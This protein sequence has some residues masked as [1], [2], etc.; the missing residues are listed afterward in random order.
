MNKMKKMY[1]IWGIIVVL[2][3]AL[4]TAFGFLYKNK[5]SVYK[6]L[7]EKLVNAEK[8]YADAKFL[9]PQNSEIVKVTAKEMIEFGALDSL[10]KDG[11][12]CD[13]YATIQ[14]KGTVFEYKGYVS[15]ENYKTKGFEN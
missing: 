8:K 7:E 11:K 4:L 13:G 15:C 2:V 12:S 1:A 6:D 3:F 14:K 9:Y 10:E 5:S